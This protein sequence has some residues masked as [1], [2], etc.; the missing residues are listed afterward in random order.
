MVA[1]SSTG[2]ESGVQE[3]GGVKKKNKQTHKHPFWGADFIGD[4]IK[5]SS[6]GPGH[7]HMHLF[8]RSNKVKYIKKYY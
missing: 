7:L 6:K 4:C 1:A 8:I 2:E 5:G 3:G